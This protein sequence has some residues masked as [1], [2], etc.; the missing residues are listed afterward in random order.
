MKYVQS[1]PFIVDPSIRI[2]AQV[3]CVLYQELSLGQLKSITEIVG[4]GRAYSQHIHF[5]AEV[6]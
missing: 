2:L 4:A 1:N 5:E 3:L 6:V